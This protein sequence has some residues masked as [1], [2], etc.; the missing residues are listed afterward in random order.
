MARLAVI[1]AL[2]GAFAFTAAW[3]ALGAHTGWTR[4]KIETK[5]V[6]PVTE[7]EFIEYRQG[8][9]P[10]IDFLAAGLGGCAILLG[11]GLIL[12]RFKSTT[13]TS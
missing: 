12:S 2:V 8:F 11:A 7:I 9:V 5:K 6:D 13:Q 3:L 4:M 1:L 10:G